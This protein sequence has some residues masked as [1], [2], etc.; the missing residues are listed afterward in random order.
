MSDQPRMSKVLIACVG[1]FLGAGKTTALMAAA[2]E[3]MRRGLRVGMIT[4]DQG[5]A[6][7][8]TEVMRSF[9]LPTEEITGGCFCCKF[10]VLI[11]HAQRLLDQA[12]PDV[13]LAEAVG[14][15][16]EVI[17]KLFRYTLSCCRQ[18][19]RI[20]YVV[21]SR[22]FEM[23]SPTY[24]P[25]FISHYADITPINSISRRSRFLLSRVGCAP[26]PVAMLNFL[27]RSLTFSRNNLRRQTWSFSTSGTR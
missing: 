15:C 2:R 21:F 25:P 14:S 19:S 22:S 4:N 6:L 23:T 17:S 26:S 7:V 13:I 3:L 11:D 1:G 27:N 8:D 10:D 16:T 18:A 12:Q 5:D 20:P 9:G 24:R